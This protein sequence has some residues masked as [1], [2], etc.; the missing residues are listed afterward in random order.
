VKSGAASQDATG[1]SVILG[2]FGD[3]ALITVTVGAVNAAGTGPTASATA[4]TINQPSLTVGNSAGGYN[5]IT[6]NFSANDGGG[7][8]AT[9][10]LAVAGAGSAS[11]SCASLTVGGLWPGNGYNY[12]VTITNAANMTASAGGSQGTTAI[13]ATVLCSV[14]SYCGRGAPGGGIWV[15]P[16]PSQNG[17]SVNDVFAPDR[18]L[19]TCW[20]TGALTINAKPYGG[21]QDNRWVRI[22]FSGDNYIPFAWVSLDGGDNPGMLP[23]C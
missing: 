6:V 3:G 15:Y 2:G 1:T 12:T 8:P 10:R 4:R 21:K 20:T 23:H 22:R 14:P 18:Y 9:C 7:S 17:P 19:A 5:S 13:Y 16:T 11:G